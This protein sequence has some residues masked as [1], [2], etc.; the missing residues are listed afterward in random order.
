MIAVK[1]D[2]T[3]L[4][5]LHDIVVPEAVP[6]WPPAAGWYIL[7]TLILI[8]MFILISQK[9]RQW[10]QNRYRRAAIRE[11]QLLRQASQ[12]SGQPSRAIAGIDQLLKRVA[13]VAWPRGDVASLSG[14]D[15][16]KFLIHS[17][18]GNEF[19]NFQVEKLLGAAYSTRIGDQVSNG[20]LDQLFDAAGRWIKQ[21]RGQSRNAEP[22]SRP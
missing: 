21:H 10:T 15:W 7:G 20:Q 11:L 1:Q 2:P 5:N 18:R 9:V 13:L 22:G 3:N 12:N 14:P 19:T 6:W 16:I 17:G 4:D 8:A